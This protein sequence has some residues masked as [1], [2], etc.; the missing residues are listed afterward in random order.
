[1]VRTSSTVNV[2]RYLDYRKFLRDWYTEKKRSRTSFS[3]RCFSKR[4]GFRSTNFFKLVMEGSRNLTEKSLAKFVIGLKL[5]K[6]EQEFF[7]NLVFFNQSKT[8][9][10]RDSYYQRMLQSRK[11]SQLQPIEKQQ[12]EFYAAWY[13]PVVRE[14]VASKDFDGTA[15]WLTERIAPPITVSQAERSIKLL[16]TLGMIEKTADNR[17]KQAS[18]IIST[19]AE[20]SSL[21]LF[22]YHKNLLDLSKDILE[23]VPAEER[24]VSAMTLGVMKERI[25]ELKKK[26]QEFR[27]EVLKLVS[28]DVHPDEVVQLDI[29][30]FPLTKQQGEKSK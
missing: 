27:R 10:D 1:M 4:A 26:I 16:E 15:E 8:H 2:F 24:D 23:Q 28:T 6:Q 17:W 18:S 25:P 30:M 19:G 20:V 29:Q 9:E 22:N 14:L 21:A 12:Y 7:Q 11:F 5:N 13:H 3:F